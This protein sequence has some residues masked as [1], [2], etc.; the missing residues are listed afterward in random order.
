MNEI[1]QANQMMFGN[2]PPGR[3]WARPNA[4]SKMKKEWAQRIKVIVE[5]T[6]YPA[7]TS[8]HVNLFVF[9][10]DMRRDFDNVV[11]GASKIL[12]DGMVTCGALPGDGRKVVLSVSP[13]VAVRKAF[14]GVAVVLTPER[15]ASEEEA[16]AFIA[17]WLR[18]D[19]AMVESDHG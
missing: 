12:L 2:P 3:P 7:Q 4:Y 16:N 17:Y 5:C 10:K 19:A 15:R 18:N 14:P 6:K 8:G 11:S 9:E 13:W 1:I